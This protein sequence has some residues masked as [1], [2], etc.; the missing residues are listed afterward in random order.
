MCIIHMND[1]FLERMNIMKLNIYIIITVIIVGWVLMSGW[2]TIN[3]DT[4]DKIMSK[5]KSYLKATF[6]GGCFWCSEA[7]F[8]KAEGVIDAISGYTGG[9]SDNPSYREVAAGKTRH[10]EAVQV[11]YDPEKISYED[12]LDVFWRHID[13]TDDGGQFV[14]RGAQYRSVIFYHDDEQKQLAEETKQLLDV[15]GKF[16][17]PIATEIRKLE[18]F[19]PAEDYHQDYYKKNP[20]RYKSYRYG[21]GRDSFIKKVWKEK[22]NKR[23]KV[24]ID[25]KYTKPDDKVLKERLNAL[26]YYVTQEEGTERPF[27]NEY[28]D[29][30]KEGIYVDIVS[31]EPL[32]SSQDKF[33]SGTGWPSF[34]KPLEPDNIVKKTDKS[35]FMTR[36]EIRSRHADSHLGHVFDDGPRPTGLRYCMN[37]AAMRFITKENL[38]KEGYGD[39]LE[40]FEE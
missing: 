18:R 3:E 22:D 29:N 31:G 36:T 19:Y 23:K 34:T 25:S 15:S 12:L 38:E 5:D 40:L 2:E 1:H 24:S 39:Y 14:D 20:L 16:S 32:F 6:A 7:D 11:I 13:P 17:E 21:S 26:Q 33:E 9:K 10:V 4:K 30:K 27:D 37:S 8:E 35:L 28:W